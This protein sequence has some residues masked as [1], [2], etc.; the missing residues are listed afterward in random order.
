MALSESKLKGLILDITNSFPGSPFEAINLLTDAYDSYAQDAVDGTGD[1]PLVVN[2]SAFKSALNFDIGNTAVIAATTFESAVVEYWTG[3]TFSPSTPPPGSVAKVSSAIVTPPIP[4]G[5][6][7]T[8][9]SNTTAGIS[10]DTK[11]Q[12]MAS[13]L[14]SMTITGAGLIQHMI[15]SPSGPVPGPPIPFTIS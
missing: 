9:F 15:P 13:A 14:H 8:V 11:A 3:A 6:L 1:P 5:L 12:E 4:N 7:L 10:A 2:K